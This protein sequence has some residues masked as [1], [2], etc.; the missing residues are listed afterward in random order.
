VDF[1]E[2]GLPH[3]R[4][5]QEA[6]A[7]GIDL[8]TFSGDKLLGG[9]QAGIIAGAQHLTARLRNNPL[10]R[11]LRVDK[12]TFAGLV[13]TLRLYASVEAR[14]QI[15]LL[16]ML[17]ASMEELRARAARYRKAIPHAAIVDTTA[18]VGGGSL[19]EQGLPSIAL[20]YAKDV[21]SNARRLRH[22]TPAIV[23]RVEG[24]RLLL[25]LRSILPEQDAEAIAA[26][27]NTLT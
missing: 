4:T 8:V 24:G 27:Q 7:D 17:G 12:L 3:E 10:M 18:Y 5:V 6:I 16:R 23:P 1:A 21:E 15:P 14:H 13:E 22:G 26:L 19:P 20:A 2:Y 25:D 9:P 11:A